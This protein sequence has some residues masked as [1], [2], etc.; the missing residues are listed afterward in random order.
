MKQAMNPAVLE[1]VAEHF[2]VLGDPTR[3]AML[4]ML[5]EREEM[6][7]GQFVDALGYSQA[8]VSKH[9]RTLHDAGILERRAAGTS[10]FY[11]I[12]DPS[13]SVLCDIV[14]DRIREQAVARAQELAAT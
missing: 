11:S 9:L 2:R 3:L 4:Q 12:A 1:S 13:I 5:L 8:N 10:A 14:C 6:N 7:V